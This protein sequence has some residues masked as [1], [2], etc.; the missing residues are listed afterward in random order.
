MNNCI[1]ANMTAL[2]EW[3]SSLPPAAPCGANLEYDQEYLLLM[4]RMAPQSD[5]QYGSF[6]ATA[7]APNW[8][9]LERDCRRLLLRSR[10]IAV[11]IL[12][13][14]CRTRLAQADGLLEGLMLLTALYEQ[15]ACEL[16]PQLS[17]D[18]QFDPQVRANALAALV[19]PDGLL[20]DIRDIEIIS[21]GATR[22]LLKD[23]ERAHAVPR[24]PEA[25]LPEAVQSRLSQLQHNGDAKLAALMRA[26]QLSER[27]QQLMQENL[28]EAAPDLHGLLNLLSLPGTDV[29]LAEVPQS[30]V[31]TDDVVSAAPALLGLPAES[32]SVAVP[33]TA[34]LIPAAPPVDEVLAQRQAALQ[35]IMQAHDWFAAHEPS[36]PVADLLRQAQKSVG[37]R[38]AEV[39]DSIPLTL[40]QQW[41]R[42]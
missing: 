8:A 7:P 28:Q 19:D 31:A 38:Y 33:A 5:V 12:F 13:V 6:I 1:T 41:E 26:R 34:E 24:I 2:P 29:P 16:H 37:K 20:A 27:L 3:L 36:S 42:D 9:E 18:G 40:L 10:D 11:V 32:L 30:C 17:I 4:A 22:L 14:R 25:R 15:H 39:A 23:V 21:Q 35:L